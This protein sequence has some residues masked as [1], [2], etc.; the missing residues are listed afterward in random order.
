MWESR[1]QQEK[2]TKPT[3]SDTREVKAKYIREKYVNKR[4]LRSTDDDSSRVLLQAILENDMARALYAIGIGSDTNQ[5]FPLGDKEVIQSFIPKEIEFDLVVRYPLVLAMIKCCSS[6]DGVNSMSTHD[7]SIDSESDCEHYFPMAELLLLNGCDI[8]TKD[9][10][11]GRVLADMIADSQ[12][13]SDEGIEYL[14]VK[15]HLRGNLLI[16]RA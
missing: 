10:E 8:Q 16:K 14:N 5:P 6:E 7:D 12:V 1:L 13:V 4:F 3:A 2:V 11:T 15:N 9:K